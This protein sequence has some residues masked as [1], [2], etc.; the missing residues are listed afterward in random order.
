MEKKQGR[1]MNLVGQPTGD[2]GKGSWEEEKFPLVEG[3]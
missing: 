2:A 1:E 3:G